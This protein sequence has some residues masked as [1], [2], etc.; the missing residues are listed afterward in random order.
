MEDDIPLLDN[1]AAASLLSPT[2]W[3]SRSR[4]RVQRWV[5]PWPPRLR[6][7]GPNHL[8]AQGAPGTRAGSRRRVEAGAWQSFCSPFYLPYALPVA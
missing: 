2:L 3:M 7:A 5:A 1:T 8:P 6:A 4:P